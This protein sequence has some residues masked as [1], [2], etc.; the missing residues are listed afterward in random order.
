MNQTGEADLLIQIQA[1]SLGNTTEDVEEDVYLGTEVAKQLQSEDTQWSLNTILIIS[2]GPLGVV[3][4]VSYIVHWYQVSQKILN[5]KKLREMG[6]VERQHPKASAMLS[7][8]ALERETGGTFMNMAVDRHDEYGIKM[9]K[10]MR[11]AR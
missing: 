11:L 2:L 8:R 10:D 6:E 3:L 1:W 7:I 5:N 9:V 4:L